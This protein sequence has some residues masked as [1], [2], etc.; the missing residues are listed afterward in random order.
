MVEDILVDRE[1]EA[2]VARELGDTYSEGYYFIR[3]FSHESARFDT[4]TDLRDFLE[5]ALEAV[6]EEL[7]ESDTQ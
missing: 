4:L 6:E 1:N 2:K 3:K 7:V 5:A